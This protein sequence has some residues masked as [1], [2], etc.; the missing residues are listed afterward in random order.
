M[1]D[2]DE[3]K[4]DTWGQRGYQQFLTIQVGHH[5]V[6][7]TIGEK[8]V[9]GTT[10]RNGYIDLLVHD[11]ELEPGWHT[12][13]IE[14]ANA[15]AVEVQLLIVD[16]AA[17]IGI[18]SDIDDTVLVTWLPRALTA[19]WNSWAKRPSKRQACLLYTSDAADE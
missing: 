7:V 4:K 10:D 9:T 16:P 17:K 15:N 2:P 6:S 11:H 14:A 8:T 18:I 3:G 13:T 5:D 12:A 1:H 19:A